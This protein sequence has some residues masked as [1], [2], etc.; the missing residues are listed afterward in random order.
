MGLAL[1]LIMP[2]MTEAAASHL[3]TLLPRPAE[4]FFEDCFLQ[5]VAALDR[6]TAAYPDERVRLIQVKLSSGRSHTVAT[7]TH[8]GEVYGWDAFCGVFNVSI[9][10]ANLEAS[11]TA[12][13]VQRAHERAARAMNPRR[14]KVRPTRPSNDIATILVQ[15]AEIR[16]SLLPHTDGAIYVVREERRRSQPVLAIA[17]YGQLGI[18]FPHIGT[19]VTELPGRTLSELPRMVV[20]AA[21]QVAGFSKPAVRAELSVRSGMR[22]APRKAPPRLAGEHRRGGRL[23]P[24]VRSAMR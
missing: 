17:A 23:K 16:E 13:A 9:S 20:N 24:D 5:A 1:L 21:C 12:A 3:R 11:R 19:A 18:Y 10:A 4:I 8:Q 14:P 6:Y 15:L 22:E 2:C 7:F